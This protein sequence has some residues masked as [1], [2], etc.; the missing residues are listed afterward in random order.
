[1]DQI[2][3]QLDFNQSSDVKKKKLRSKSYH[4]I[5]AILFELFLGSTCLEDLSNELFYEFFDYLD[6]CDIH[7]AF[8]D[9]N[10]RFQNLLTNSLLPLNINLSS[11]S[12][13]TLEQRCRHVIIPNKHRIISLHLNDDSIVNDFFD[14][15]NIDSS[16][17]HLESV[18]LSGISDYKTPV[19]LFYLNGLPR[20]SSLTIHLDEDDYYN[21]SDIYRLIFRLPYLKYS[22]LSISDE[23]DSNIFIPM[24]INEKPS[25]IERLVLNFGCTLDELTSLLLHTPYLQHLTCEQ[26]TG[27]GEVNR[28]EERLTLPYLTHISIAN[29]II[30]FDEFEVFIK[31]ICSQLQMLR[32]TTFWNSGYLDAYRWKQLIKYHMPHLYEFHFDDHMFIDYDDDASPN[33]ESINQ[34]TSSFWI[35]RQWFFELE[36]DFDEFVYSIH[37]YRYI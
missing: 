3:R 22:K 7:K 5:F 15:C 12:Y 16:F 2:K 8:S 34:F 33:F 11:K 19:I 1:M 28:K 26:L 14:F 13:S 25:T 36:N 4:N 20:L 21:L 23:G 32:L 10:I 29:C 37:P 6:G 18:V 9:L 24:S 17:N 27:M 30:A 35:E 31:K